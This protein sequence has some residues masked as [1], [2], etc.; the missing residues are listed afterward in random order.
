M[1]G[2]YKALE[3][4]QKHNIS[5]AILKARSPSCGSKQI[6]DGNFSGTIVDGIGTTAALLSQHGIHV[7]D[8][9][10]IDDAI[11]LAKLNNL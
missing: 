1:A 7:F 3:L 10:Q 11:K 8:E 6:Y 5:V 4:A 2:A 9:T